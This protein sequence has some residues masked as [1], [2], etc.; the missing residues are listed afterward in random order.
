MELQQKE[1]ADTSSNEYENH[2]TVNS[3][4]VIPS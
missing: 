3:I 4:K 2:K 1:T